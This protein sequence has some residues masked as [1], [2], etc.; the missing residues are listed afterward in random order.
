MKAIGEQKSVSTAGS[1]MATV[2]LVEVMKAEDGITTASSTT[3]Q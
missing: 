1:R 2:T 3:A